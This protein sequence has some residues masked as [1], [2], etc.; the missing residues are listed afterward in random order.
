MAD[1]IE[2]ISLMTVV[3]LQ[4]ELKRRGLKKSGN[5][6]VLIQRLKEVN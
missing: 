5:K 6:A 1:T 3:E 2:S 4:A